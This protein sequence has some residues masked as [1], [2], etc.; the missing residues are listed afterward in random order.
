MRGDPRKLE[1]L[2]QALMATI[3]E[4]RASVRVGYPWWLRPFLMRDV[5]AITLGRRI[6]I[7]EA[8][9]SA[10][11]EC[12]LRHELAHVRQVQRLGLVRFLWLYT[13]EFARHWIRLRNVSAAYAAISFEIEARAAEAL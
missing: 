10:S 7:R 11:F 1:Q 13:S 2:P 9:A 3:A 5:V 8:M 4:S 6:Y 12:L